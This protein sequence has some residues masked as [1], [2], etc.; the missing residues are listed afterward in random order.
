VRQRPDRID[1]GL[2]GWTFP[3]GVDEQVFG[4]RLQIQEQVLLAREVAR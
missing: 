4:L 2:A 1:D 3:E